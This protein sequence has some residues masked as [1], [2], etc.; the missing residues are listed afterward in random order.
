MEYL[1]GS[2]ATPRD[3]H[4]TRYQKL[5]PRMWRTSWTTTWK[6][7][8]FCFLEGSPDIKVLILSCYPRVT[9][10]W[11][12]GMN[13][14][15]PVNKVSHTKFIDLWEQFHPNIVAKPMTDLCFTCQQNTL[16]LIRSA[17]LPE[18]E[19]S[20]CVRTQQEHLNCVQDERELQK[21]L[22]GSEK[23][24]WNGTQHNCFGS[25]SRGLLTWQYYALLFWL[26]ATGTRSKQSYAAWTNIL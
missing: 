25:G 6:K 7:M 5:L 16:K 3:Y 22:S 24:F 13:F 8:P 18:R 10:K 14:K 11:A 2:M 4:P 23:Q 20:E 1:K 15:G 17:N 21:C 26:C 19:K 12:C 9:Q